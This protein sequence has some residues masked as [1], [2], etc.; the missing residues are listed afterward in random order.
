MD[1]IV[2]G[3]PKDEAAALTAEL[4]YD[5]PLLDTGEPFHFWAIEAPAGV[6][7]EL[8]LREAGF[9]VVW[10]SDL[11]PYR[12]RKVYILNGAHTAM[13]M[14]GLLAGKE[15]VGECMA[16]PEMRAWVAAAI[17]EEII[18]TL[19]L[20]RAELESFASAVMERFSNPFVRHRLMSIA[21]NSVSKYRARILP[22][23]ERYIAL[24]GR[25]PA[26]LS[27]ALAALMEVYS[28]GRFPVQDDPAIL[29]A[30]AAKPSVA[31]V[32]ARADWWGRDLCE[33]PGFEAAV[34][35]A[36]E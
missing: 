36:L 16:D 15:T 35:A 18:P 21:L 25:A 22:A 20:P 14:V 19:T 30:F 7:R 23:V 26:K 11:K 2:T 28:S 10:T 9:D 5:D 4:G 3:Y 33:L 8:P 32:L 27:Q 13:T 1:R 12:D 6:E 31:E 29:A 24:H 34:A 17:H